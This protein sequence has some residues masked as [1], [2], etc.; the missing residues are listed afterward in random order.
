V[1]SR[2]KEEGNPRC[3]PEGSVDEAE[4]PPPPWLQR[5]AEE[6]VRVGCATETAW[7][8]QQRQLQVAWKGVVRDHRQSKAATPA[9]G[10][11]CWAPG[12]IFDLQNTGKPMNFRVIPAAFDDDDGL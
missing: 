5:G 3:L 9:R 11:Q 2:G 10:G 7:P 1:Y 8:A 12:H 6:V 4:R